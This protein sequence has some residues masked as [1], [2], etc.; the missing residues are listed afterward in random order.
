M[1]ETA[2]EPR[3]KPRDEE[4]NELN[5]VCFFAADR[6]G[7]GYYRM[8]LPSVALCRVG[9][10]AHLISTDR[11]H[12]YNIASTLVLQRPADPNFE[13]LVDEAKERGM[14]VVFELDDNL[15]DL[16]DWNQASP[17]W[18]P[19]R[20]KMAETILEKCDR[21]TTTTEPLAEVLRQYIDDVM[22]VPNCVFDYH[23]LELP[24]YL[25]YADDIV[26]GWVGSSFH[27]KDT[28]VFKLLIPKVLSAFP[29]TAFLMMGESPPR[30]LE[31]YF[32]RIISL[33]FVETIYYHQI[34]S[35]F[36]IDIGLAPLVEHPFNECKSAI[37]LHEYLY[38]RT[39]PICSSVG[40]YEQAK[41]EYADSCIL[42]P[43]AED[44]AGS[45]DDW[46]QAIEH[47]I[48]NIED[49]REKANKGR[50]YILDNYNIEN[51]HIIDLYKKAY[52]VE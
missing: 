51:K 47:C 2:A 5:T 25:E 22:V 35:T 33:P 42:I 36:K 16:P 34:L 14:K 27:Q 48:K 19:V 9:V 31:P 12:L 21:A 17:F 3:R 32:N 26:I 41:E 39:Y 50:Q 8:L 46:M 6:W 44:H 24:K 45:V 28:E 38:T 11:I 4:G 15:W 20:L 30:E 13:A 29:N 7:C 37:K 10:P 49:T 18:T 52:Y 40:P 1:L 43:A 23:Y